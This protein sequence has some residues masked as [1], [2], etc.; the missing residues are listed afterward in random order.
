MANEWRPEELF[1]E[2]LARDSRN[3]FP[4]GLD[5]RSPNPVPTIP[6]RGDVGASVRGAGVSEAASIFFNEEL[7]KEAGVAP[8]AT[9]ELEYKPMKESL[10]CHAGG[11]PQLFGTDFTFEGALL[12]VGAAMDLQEDEDLWVRYAVRVA[13]ATQATP[14]LDPATFSGGV[15]VG[16]NQFSPAFASA[17]EAGSSVVCVIRSKFG[18]LVTPSGLGATWTKVSDVSGSF[19]WVGTGCDGVGTVVTLSGADTFGA[20]IM[21]VSTPLNPAGKVN[22]T[23]ASGGGHIATVTSTGEGI[24]VTYYRGGAGQVVT[25]PHTFS[26]FPMTNLQ[27]GFPHIGIVEAAGEVVKVETNYINAFTNFAHAV[28]VPYA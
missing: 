1:E 21:K 3:V 4:L 10:H 13:A 19:V 11:Y 7:L 17:P 8:D 25:F 26:A 18:P 2:R 14:E 28:F 23:V 24:G 6:T 12:T 27:D 22:N 20:K 16:E 5:G 9:Y 15:E